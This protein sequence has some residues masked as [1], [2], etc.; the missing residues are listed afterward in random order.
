MPLRV[1]DSPQSH[2]AFA[3]PYTAFLCAPSQVG[4]TTDEAKTAAKAMFAG[5]T[6]ADYYTSG[7]GDGL[8]FQNLPDYGLVT[9]SAMVIQ[10]ASEGAWY[11]PSGQ[12]MREGL[13]QYAPTQTRPLNHGVNPRPL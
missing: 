10:E 13:T 1:K 6:T 3:R 4:A 12:S 5:R 8:S 2:R 7:K 9:T 11:S